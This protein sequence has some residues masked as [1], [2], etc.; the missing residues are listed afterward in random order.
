MVISFQNGDKYKGSS[1]NKKKD[2]WISFLS[3]NTKCKSTDQV[4]EP[5][6]HRAFNI[7][8]LLVLLLTLADLYILQSSPGMACQ[9]LLLSLII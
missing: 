4:D 7:Y 6:L 3:E 9:T 8:F 1:N 5:N 2:I